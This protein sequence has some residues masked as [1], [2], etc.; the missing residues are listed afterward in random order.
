MSIT[1]DFEHLVPDV[2]LDA[3]E[4]ALGVRMSGLATPLPSYINRVYE[5]QTMDGTRLIAKFYRPGRWSREAI[6]EEHAFTLDCVADE[7]PVV[8]PMRLP[9]GAT[10]HEADGICFAV[11]EK[12]MGRQFEIRTRTDWLRVGRLLG[13]LHVVGS[14]Q[15]ATHRTNLHPEE[16]T[17]GHVDYLL[18]NGLVTPGY[19]AEFEEVADAILGE[20]Y[21]PFDDPEFIRIHGDCHGGNILTRPG[22]GLMMIDFDDMMVGPPVHDFWLLLPGPVKE[23]RAELGLLLRGYEQFREF[24]DTTLRLVEPLRAMRMIYYLAWCAHQ[25]DDH[26]FQHNNPQWGSDAFWQREVADLTTQLQAIRE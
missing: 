14:R 23:C 17:S 5:T 15:D 25:V 24:D 8:A 7:I 4:D 2:M 9:S 16:S 19:R 6:E 26:R 21:E 22:E 1:P 11:F 13:R 10:L 18:D 20:I 12:R 3:V